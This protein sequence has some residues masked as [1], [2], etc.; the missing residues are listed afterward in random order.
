MSGAGHEGFSELCGALNIDRCGVG[1]LDQGE[2]VTY[3][4]AIFLSMACLSATGT[5]RRINPSIPAA[6][7]R[8]VQ[9]P[10]SESGLGLLL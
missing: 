4:C 7:T 10:D 8:T 1:I 2:G 3:D 5:A 9:S 6:A